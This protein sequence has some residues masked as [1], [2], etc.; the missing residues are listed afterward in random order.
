MYYLELIQRF[1]EF[2][3]VVKVSPTEISLYL[4]LL[5][6]GHDNDRYDFKISDKELGRQLRLTSVTINS[7]KKR[8][9]SLGL[10]QFQTNKGLPCY[11]R[12]S[13]DYPFDTKSKDKKDQESSDMENSDLS[14]G[15]ETNIKTEIKNDDNGNIPSIDEFIDYAKTIDGFESQL[16][17]AIK[18][19]YSSWLNKGWKN[20]SNR[21]IGNWKLTL[22]STLPFMKNSA[23][24]NKISLQDIP[25]I[26]RP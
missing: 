9:K 2:N 17:P 12:L 4:Y 22:K 26:K 25:D 10:L 6:I 24:D 8:L 7:T 16:E 15:L 13:L 3:K 11:Y 19:K 1:W 23:E 14:T 21:P 5:K 20:T 18:K